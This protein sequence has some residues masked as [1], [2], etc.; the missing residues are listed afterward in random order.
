MEKLE[1]A[2]MEI[3]LGF[4]LL[5]RSLGVSKEHDCQGCK[6]EEQERI[7]WWKQRGWYGMNME[8][9]KYVIGVKNDL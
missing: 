5:V 9:Q 2:G 7:F 3:C 4:S 6:E 1:E 8:N